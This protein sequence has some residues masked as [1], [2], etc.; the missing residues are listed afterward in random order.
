MAKNK[1]ASKYTDAHRAFIEPLW[2]QGVTAREIADKVNAK[3]SLTIT[4]NAIIS[5][6]DRWKLPKRESGGVWRIS[7]AQQRAQTILANGGYTG[8]KKRPPVL[9]PPGEIP[10]PIGILGEFAQD[11]CC[12][13]PVNQD[14]QE[15]QVCGHPAPKGPYCAGHHRIAHQPSHKPVQAGAY[16]ADKIR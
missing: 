9:E 14:G 6:V 5:L 4:R 10:G 11:N 12:K 1:V 16:R 8:P 13:W 2:T 7:G 15:Y 3:F